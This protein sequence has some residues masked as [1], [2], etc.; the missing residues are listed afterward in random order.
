M[1]VVLSLSILNALGAGEL[2]EGDV[3]KL[4]AKVFG[5]QFAICDNSDVS[6][7][8]LRRSP[9]PGALTAAIFNPRAAC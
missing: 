4:D 6:S 8:A 7:K 5:D 1:T 9:K 3:L 2:G